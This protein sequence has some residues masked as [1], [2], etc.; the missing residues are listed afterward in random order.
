MQSLYINMGDITCREMTVKKVS[1]KFLFK[2][3]QCQATPDSNKVKAEY[4][5]WQGVQK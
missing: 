4:L 2:C 5:T 3:Q 1:F